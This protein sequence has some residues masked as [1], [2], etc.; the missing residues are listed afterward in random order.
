MALY[1]N[2]NVAG[3]NAQRQIQFSSNSLDRA[4]T[5]LS[6]GK[7]INGAVD[8]AAGLQISD[9]LTSQIQGFE[10]GNRNANDGISVVQSLEGAMDEVTV[11]LQRVR[12]L[13]QQAANGSN[14]DSD[15]VALQQEV[16]DLM[17]EVNRIASDT[18]FAGENVLDGRYQG[19][20][21][22][23]ADSV[24]VINFDMRNVG[25]TT[26]GNNSLTANGGFTLSGIAAIATAVTNKS[27]TSIVGPGLSAIGSSGIT[28]TSF[29]F[30]GV[31]LANAISISNQDNAQMVFAG[32]DSLIAVIDKKRAELGAIQN[33]FQ[34]IMR[35]QSNISENL[36]AARSR[37]LDADFAKETAEL[38]RAQIMQQASISILSQARQSPQIAL[39]LLS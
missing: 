23:G 12:V 35:N 9:R 21:H 25:S 19:S 1:V 32:M 39:S 28:A 27:N 33:R 14:A 26:N 15:R 22:V 8:D 37:I 18:T 36:S 16:R 6:S 17:A 34:S 38:T 30:T 5:R 24:Q 4:L 29:T 3:L 2:T 20:F 10:Q 13:A 7:R 11:M 31:Y